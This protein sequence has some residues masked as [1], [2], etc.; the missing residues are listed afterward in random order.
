MK[1]A[2]AYIDTE[3]LTDMFYWNFL[4]DLREDPESSVSLNDLPVKLIISA[5]GLRT[6]N[7][8][9]VSSMSKITG[10]SRFGTV[11]T[12]IQIGPTIAEWN[13]SSL[14]QLSSSKEYSNFRALAV[15]DVTAIDRERFEKEYLAK[16]FAEIARWNGMKTYSSIRAN[17]QTFTDTLLKILGQSSPFGTMSEDMKGFVSTL[18]NLDKQSI[19]FSFRWKGQEMDF[20]DHAQLDRF[21]YDSKD[22]LTRDDLQLLKAFDRVFWLRY[23]A[24]PKDDDP[25]NSQRKK[26]FAPMQDDVLG[27]FF[28]NPSRT[29][30]LWRSFDQRSSSSDETDLA[31]A[32]YSMAYPKNSDQINKTN[33]KE[34]SHE[35][36]E[37]DFEEDIDILFFKATTS[38]LH[39]R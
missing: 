24:I 39:E 13:N 35:D 12:A 4:E 20:R 18:F 34:A 30:S 7:T 1:D 23:L 26:T 29:G 27:C 3:Q 33:I 15:I 21:C 25:V 37:V 8:A 36:G 2:S 17:C 38:T 19:H 31:C 9:I 22:D 5:I 32:H 16:I 28:D 11:H 14:V 6:P 10:V